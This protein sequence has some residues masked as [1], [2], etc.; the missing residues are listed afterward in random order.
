MSLDR[1]AVVRVRILM[2]AYEAVPT[3][4]Q[5]PAYVD[6]TTSTKT[7]CRNYT[8]LRRLLIFV[9]A[10]CLTALAAFKAGQWSAK[11]GYIEAS[12]SVSNS[13]TFEDTE[14]AISEPASNSTVAMPGNGKYS[15]G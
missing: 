6:H 10:F 14:P 12:D 1:D 9:A 2:A 8:R 7:A 15:V 3:D 5:P 11:P 4:E 13:T